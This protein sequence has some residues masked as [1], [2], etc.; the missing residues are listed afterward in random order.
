[1]TD[2]GSLYRLLVLPRWHREMGWEVGGR[3]GSLKARCSPCPGA[4]LGT[5]T[6]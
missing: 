3:V 1:M 6:V 5:P 2:S 4:L